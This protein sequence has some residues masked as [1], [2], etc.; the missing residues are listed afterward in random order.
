MYLSSRYLHFSM[1]AQF[2]SSSF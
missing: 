2:T 1:S